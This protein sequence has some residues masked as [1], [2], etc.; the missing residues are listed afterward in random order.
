VKQARAEA[1]DPQTVLS[2]YRSCVVQIATA[3]LQRVATRIQDPRL[4]D[5]TA[6]LSTRGFRECWDVSAK[7]VRLGI[8]GGVG[9]ERQVAFERGRYELVLHE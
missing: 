7:R 1:S 6:E 5:C 4:L 2:F 8:Q 3:G 9:G